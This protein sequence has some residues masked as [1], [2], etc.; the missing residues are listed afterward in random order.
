MRKFSA[1]G[2]AAGKVSGGAATPATVVGAVWPAPV[3]VG[4]DAPGDAIAPA[5]VVGLSNETMGAA[6]ND[7]RTRLPMI[8]APAPA[9]H[10]RTTTTLSAS[11]SHC[12]AVW[13]TL[14]GLASWLGVASGVAAMSGR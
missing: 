11:I 10:A 8:N 4:S 3:L 12:T 6:T 13:W 7:S 1:L 5:V 14:N 9:K 2:S